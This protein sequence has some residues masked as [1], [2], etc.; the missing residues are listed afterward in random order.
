MPVVDLPMAALYIDR[1]H[2]P[3]NTRSDLTPADN[4]PA[5]SGPE[6]YFMEDMIR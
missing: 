6:E 3:V 4:R 1:E 5:G 2:S